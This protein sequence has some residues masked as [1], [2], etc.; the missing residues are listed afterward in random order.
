MQIDQSLPILYG[1]SKKGKVKQWRT[2]VEENEDGTAMINVES[3]YVGGKIRLSPKLIKKGKNI[4]K[5]NETT[6]FTQALSEVKSAWSKR[7]NVNYELEIMDPNN[8]VPRVM[9]P[10]LAKDPKKGKIVFPCYIQPKLNGVC[11]LTEDIKSEILHHTR[12]GKL[13]TAVSHLDKY[14][15]QMNTPAPLHGELYKH[16]WSLQKISSYTKKLKPDSHLLEYW[17]YDIAWLGIPFGDRLTYLTSHI[18]QSTNIPIKMTPTFLV[19]NYAEAKAYHDSFVA[20]GFEGAI[21]KNIAGFY[22]FEFRSD[23]IEKMKDFQNA[24][25]EIVGGKEGVGTDTGCIIY[26]CKIE[27]GLEFDVRPRGT[28]EERQELFINLP[29][30]IGEM[31]TIRFPEY[32]DSGLPSQPVGIVVRDYE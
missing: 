12:G 15:S 30:D 3:G 7:R 1:L 16:G 26:R 13:F 31:L 14:I 21:L 22:I 8:Y 11:N 18:P 2:W 17:V 32:T 25:F 28:V 6:P 29:N 23:N 20:D 27:S 19:N 9:L 24:E 10:Q 5:S 4:G